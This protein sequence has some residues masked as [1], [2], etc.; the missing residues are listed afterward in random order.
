MPVIP[1]WMRSHVIT[2]HCII[3]NL[4][5]DR[6]SVIILSL[7]PIDSRFKNVYLTTVKLE[8]KKDFKNLSTHKQASLS[9]YGVVGFIQPGAPSRFGQGRSSE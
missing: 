8:S 6:V 9:E 2:S 5:V 7:S 3:V 1:F 4:L